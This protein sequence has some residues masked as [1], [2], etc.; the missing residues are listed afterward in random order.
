MRRGEY[1]S[2]LKIMDKND[3][4]TYDKYLKGLSV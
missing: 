3:V 2:A 4:K 1:L